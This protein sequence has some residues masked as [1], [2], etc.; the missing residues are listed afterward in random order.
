MRDLVEQIDEIKRK[1]CAHKVQTAADDGYQVC[2]EDNLFCSRLIEERAPFDQATR[3]G[4]ASERIIE[5]DIV[6][7]SS[8]Q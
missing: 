7:V 3:S 8:Q 2:C 5:W 1:Y 6:H 4:C